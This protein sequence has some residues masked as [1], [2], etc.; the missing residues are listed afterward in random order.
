V[1]DSKCVRGLQNIP[2]NSVE[3][4]VVN[5]NGK[6]EWT[7]V[8]EGLDRLDRDKREQIANWCVCVCVLLLCFVVLVCHVYRP[9]LS[10]CW[11]AGDARNPAPCCFPLRT[12][13]GWV[14]P[15]HCPLCLSPYLPCSPAVA[16]SGL[17]PHVPPACH[18]RKQKRRSSNARDSSERFTICRHLTSPTLWL[19][20][21]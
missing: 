10:L 15:S 4:L 6:P 12:A 2:R 5:E 11:H 19:R 3:R 17:L 16:S 9:C 18:R 8:L 1:P 20:H 14:I 7:P 21:D 13:L